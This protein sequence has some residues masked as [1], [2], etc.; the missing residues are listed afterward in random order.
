MEAA[1][2]HNQDDVTHR[3][4]SRPSDFLPPFADERNQLLSKEIKVSVRSALSL[5]YA[6]DQNVL[7]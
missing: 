3:P 6:S 7:L 1:T 4:S 2:A 5:F